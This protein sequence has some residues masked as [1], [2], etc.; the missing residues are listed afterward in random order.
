MPVAWVQLPGGEE[1]D[2]D[3]G[4][5]RY[6]R[7]PDPFFDW[8]FAAGIFRFFPVERW[9]TSTTYKSH[10]QSALDELCTWTASRLFPPRSADKKNNT[11]QMGTSGMT[12]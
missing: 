9:C 8:H 6:L 4:S 11:T 10:W 2:W 3:D 12:R 7:D 5:D 1:E